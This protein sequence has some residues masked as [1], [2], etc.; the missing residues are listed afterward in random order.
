MISTALRLS[1][2]CSC[3][4]GWSIPTRWLTS[5][6]KAW[7]IRSAYGLEAATA[8]WALTIRDVAIISWARVILAVDLTVLICCRS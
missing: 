7:V 4:S 3:S 1:V 2:G 8:C 6:L 5:A